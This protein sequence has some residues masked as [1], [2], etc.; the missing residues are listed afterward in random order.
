MVIA[1]GAFVA[2]RYFKWDLLWIFAGGLAVWSGL[3]MLGM[4]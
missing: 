1:A 4:V 2:I 3:M